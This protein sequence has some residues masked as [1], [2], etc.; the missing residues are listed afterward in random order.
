MA[1]SDGTA[2]CSADTHRAPIAVAASP[3]P[4]LWLPSMLLSAVP[5]L[6]VHLLTAQLVAICL[7]AVPQVTHIVTAL[8]HACHNTV[9][10]C[11]HY[12]SCVHTICSCN[13]CHAHAWS[14]RTQPQQHRIPQ[15]FECSGDVREATVHQAWA[16]SRTDRVAVETNPLST[17]NSC[18]DIVHCASRCHSGLVCH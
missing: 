10:N 6:T 1:I 3:C 9:I 2:T 17:I 11:L 15:C 7:T 4:M 14:G 16:C 13:T 12:R 8:Q 18:S 5:L